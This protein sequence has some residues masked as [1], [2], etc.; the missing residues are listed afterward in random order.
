M[1][2]FPAIVLFGEQTFLD[3]EASFLPNHLC[4]GGVPL[5][6]GFLLSGAYRLGIF[7]V[8][9]G[10]IDGDFYVC[11]FAGTLGMPHGKDLVAGSILSERRVFAMFSNVFSMLVALDSAESALMHLKLVALSCMAAGIGSGCRVDNWSCDLYSLRLL[12]Q[13]MCHLVMALGDSGDSSTKYAATSLKR[14]FFNLLD[15]FLMAMSV[16]HHLLKHFFLCYLCNIS[17][18]VLGSSSELLFQVLHL[19][20]LDEAW[21]IEGHLALLDE[22][23][24]IH[25]S[26][27]DMPSWKGKPFF[28]PFR[29]Y[30]GES[31]GCQV[32]VLTPMVMARFFCDL[33]SGLARLLGRSELIIFA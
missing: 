1:R 16:F 31:P 21:R 13:V 15:W 22:G 19:A 5:C 14:H 11:L 28:R 3:V 2:V 12:V 32:G 30:P 26:P 17:D 23:W 25:F 10:P 8:S 18:E 29:P 7:R 6:E 9:L 24:R 27:Y 33:C 20:L 4:Q